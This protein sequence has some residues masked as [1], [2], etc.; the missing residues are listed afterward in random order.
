MR[1]LNKILSCQKNNFIMVKIQ[2]KIT[3]M[4]NVSH[5]P[6]NIHRLPENKYFLNALKKFGIVFFI[7]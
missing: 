6:A 4:F 3:K 5:V 1:F 2:K 7:P